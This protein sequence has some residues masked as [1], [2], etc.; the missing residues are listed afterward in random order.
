M[1]KEALLTHVMRAVFVLT[2]PC[3]TQ[4]Q[5]AGDPNTAAGADAAIDVELA[6]HE[7]EFSSVRFEP[8][9]RDQQPG[10]AVIFTGTHD[11]HYY[12]RPET[13]PAAGFELKVSAQ[14][15]DLDFGEAVF[16]K[17]H[18]FVD[19]T[20]TTVEVYAGNFTVFVPAKAT[21]ALTKTTVAK[22][23]DIEVLITGQACT[24]TICLQPFEETLQTSIN[25]DQR[26]SWRQISFEAPSDAEMAAEVA[27]G[28][29]YSTWFALVLA[30][31]A[32][33]GLNIMPCVWPV[34]PLI[35]MRIVEQAK[36]GRRQSVMMGLAFC[37]GILLFF[38][39]LAGANIVLQSFYDRTL[40]WGDHLRN[41]VIVTALALLMIVMAL[42]MFGIF[43]ITVPASIASKSGSGKGYAGSVGMGFLAAIL[44]TPCS[45]GILTVAFVWAQGQ[46]LFLGTLAIMVIGLGMAAP[47]AILTSMPGWLKRLPRGGR[48]MELFKQTLGFVLLVIAVKLVKAVP[49][50]DK[51]NLLYFAVIL[52]FCIW[53][54][55]AWVPYGTRFS[56]QWSVRG[57]AVLLAVSAFWFFFRPELVDW[58]EYDPARIES[59]RSDQRPVLV[60]FTADW[61]TNCE[62]VDKFVYQRKD[63]AKL[64][65][66]KGVLAFKG[67]TTKASQPATLDL[68]N[69][70]KE[71]GVP[72]TILLAP[73]ETEPVRLRELFF[74]DELRALLE[75]LPDKS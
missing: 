39:C 4:G 15:D 30:F 34:L 65:D 16:P 51:I 17:W 73:G 68:K 26:D 64:I 22:Q 19:S 43:T 11:L 1:S 21:E 2:L 37:V 7:E 62:I 55:A 61:C 33:L 53:M 60:K 38:A 27:G 75:A 58:Q 40:S 42:F 71:P 36:A 14:S 66:E 5:S 70:Y 67:D 12:A 31:I 24:S 49:E 50:P 41:P 32:G 3:C 47:Y 69:V 63:I 9:R 48:W 56:R 57:I 45:F 29:D 44:S 20:G 13:A 25:W 28:P 54:W 72:V 35:I 10:V 18:T 59:A 52:S 46:A 8:A 6:R 74:D 23:S